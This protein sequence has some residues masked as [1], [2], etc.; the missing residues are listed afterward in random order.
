[1][2]GSCSCVWSLDSWLVTTAVF[3]C[4]VCKQSSSLSFCCRYDKS[5]PGRLKNW[6]LQ[7]GGHSGSWWHPL[8][9]LQSE[10]KWHG[11]NILWSSSVVQQLHNSSLENY[12]GTN[13]NL[14]VMCQGTKFT[15]PLLCGNSCLCHS[16]VRSPSVWQVMKEDCPYIHF[17]GFISLS[18]FTEWQK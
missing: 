3:G 5:P 18:Q 4:C 8:T 12:P 7:S 14:R 13:S 15:S 2:A 17:Y 11:G 10:N 9:F 1:M 6:R 16:D